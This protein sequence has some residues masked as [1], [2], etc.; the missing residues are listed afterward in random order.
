MKK[1]RAK[2]EGQPPVLTLFSGDALNPSLESIF[3]QGEAHNNRSYNNAD[4]KQAN[5]WSKH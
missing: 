5:T 1:Y 2:H 4:S 3:T